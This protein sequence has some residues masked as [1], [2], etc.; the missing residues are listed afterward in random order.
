MEL[1]DAS[2]VAEALALGSTVGR[3]D[4]ADGFAFPGVGL[5]WLTGSSA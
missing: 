5:F 1:A 3:A 4:G 2:G